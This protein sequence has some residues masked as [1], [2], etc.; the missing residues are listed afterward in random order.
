MAKKVSKAD[1]MKKAARLK[2]KGRS[3]MNKAQLEKAVAKASGSGQGL[4]FKRTKGSLRQTKVRGGTNR[5]R[6]LQ[7]RA[8]LP[9][10]RRAASGRTYYERR[11]NRSDQNPS[12]MLGD[13]SGFENAAAFWFA[14]TMSNDQ[15]IYKFFK[16][17]IQQG[18]IVRGKDL[19]EIW[20]DIIG[21]EISDIEDRLIDFHYA[22]SKTPYI[23]D[24]AQMFLNEV[25]PYGWNQ[26]LDDFTME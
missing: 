9:G 11:V 25:T 10:K 1:L 26:I 3:T 23:A 2:I 20:R 19:E 13:Y 5:A 21:E 7:R 12:Q 8:K 14:I 6:D 15:G 18:R 16:R 4:L 24:M 22:R 17:L